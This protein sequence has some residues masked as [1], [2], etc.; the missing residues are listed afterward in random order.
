MIANT[1]HPTVKRKKKQQK[2]EEEEDEEA[3]ERFRL[4]TELY[5]KRSMKDPAD[6][7]FNC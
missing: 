7:A 6:P 1:N 4:I 2:E 3:E 5:A